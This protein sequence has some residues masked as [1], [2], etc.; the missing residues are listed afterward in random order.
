MFAKKGH[1][2]ILVFIFPYTSILGGTYGGASNDP[3]ET[4]GCSIT[5]FNAGRKT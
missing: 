3:K 4:L 1:V 5:P 2:V